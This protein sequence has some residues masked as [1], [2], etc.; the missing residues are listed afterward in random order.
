MSK[1]PKPLRDY[2]LASPIV[3]EAKTAGGIILP[4]SAKEK[5]ED[6]VVK[7][8]GKDVKEVKV[9][10]TISYKS[11]STIEKKVGSDTYILV[12]EEDIAAVN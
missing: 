12:R 4:D 10:D 7:A 8:V 1:L 5:S 2:V 9:G 11:Y 3:A 6:A